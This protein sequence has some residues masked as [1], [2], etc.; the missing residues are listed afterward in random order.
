MSNVKYHLLAR[1][2]HWIMAFGFVFMWLC[3][4]SMINFVEE[5]S[6]IESLLFSLHISV[7]FTLLFALIAR[8]VIRIMFKPP[9]I[10]EEISKMDRTGAHLAHAA[11]YALPFLIIL[12]GWAE[13]DFGGHGVQW[14]GL[15]VPQVFPTMETLGGVDLEETTETIH[16]WLAYTMLVIALV[17]IA[18]VIKHRFFDKHDVLN[19]M[20]IGRSKSL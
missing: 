15:N 4:F 9:P 16:R 17:H 12:V 6:A 14:F 7:G 5:D 11:L 18:A 19:R 10:P 13:V 1:L 20:T 3:G 8:V 2:L